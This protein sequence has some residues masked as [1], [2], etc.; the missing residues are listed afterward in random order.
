[1]L[2][3]DPHFHILIFSFML[4][5]CL[6]LASTMSADLLSRRERPSGSSVKLFCFR[7]LENLDHFS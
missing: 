1:M 4:S 2:Y 6:L 7:V 3:N 5:W